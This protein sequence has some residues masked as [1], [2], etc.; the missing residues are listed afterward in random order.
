MAVGHEQLVDEVFVL[1]L[2]GRTP[3]AAAF[4]GL[5]GIETL[6]L[7]VA[8]MRQSNDEILFRNQILIRYISVV[9]NNFGPAVIAVLIADFFEFFSNHSHQLIRILQNR[10]K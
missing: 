8:A 1:D 6:R 7:R 4:L 2:G 3:A 9:F 10:C 5:V